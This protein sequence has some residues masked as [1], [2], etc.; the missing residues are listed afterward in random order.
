VVIDFIG[1]GQLVEEMIPWVQKKWAYRIW[2]RDTEKAAQTEY[3]AKASE[4]LNMNEMKDLS[5]FVVVAAPLEHSH[6]NEWILKRQKNV[7]ASLYDFRR[8][9]M[10]FNPELT[11]NSY[12]H[13]DDFS[14]EVQ[15]QKL[16]IQKNISQAYC[17]IENWKQEEQVRAQLR[18]FGWDDL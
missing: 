4:I 12:L 14:M 18:P 15:G 5:P 3:G 6:L 11:L 9:S 1:A 8:D 7:K 2:C 13:L 17:K 10:S 16:Q